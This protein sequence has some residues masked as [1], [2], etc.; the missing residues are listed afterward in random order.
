MRSTAPA[1]HTCTLVT[2][3][4][5]RDVTGEGVRSTA[6][7]SCCASGRPR[8]CIASGTPSSWGMYGSGEM[9]NSRQRPAQGRI[10]AM[11]GKIGSPGCQ[12]QDY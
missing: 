9:I 7:T 10:Q 2:L 5:H 3:I 11:A 4:T 8:R 12:W 6:S 1:A